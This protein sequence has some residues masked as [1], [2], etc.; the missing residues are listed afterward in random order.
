[1]LSVV[2]GMAGQWPLVVPILL[3]LGL[4]PL[5]L[6]VNNKGH[7]DHANALLLWSIFLL[8]CTLLWLGQGLQSVAVLTF[9]VILLVAGLLTNLR[10]FVALLVAMLLYGT[11]LTL[12]TEVWHLRQNG[13][14]PTPLRY[15]LNYSLVLSAGA[16]AAWIA[17]TDLRNVLEDLQIQIV[18]HRDS[19]QR[20]R[21]LSQHDNLTEL[22][23]RFLGRELVEA[24]I[25][26]AERN[27]TRVALVFVDLDHFKSIDDSLGHIAGDAYLQ[28]VAKRLQASVR[29]AD[30]VARQ[31]GD[32][33]VIGLADV[34]DSTSVA[35][36]AQTVVSCFDAP[37]DL[38]GS[39]VQGSCS[40]GVAMYP[41]DG[42]DYESLLRMSD[43]AMY[44]AKAAG[45]NRYRFFGEVEDIGSHP[46]PAPDRA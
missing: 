15:W 28:Q 39:K 21:F 14:S 43:T 46:P 35:K 42:S 12:F 1:L 22:P 34:S 13:V 31:G 37:F 26:R 40:V 45:R 18:R 38:R 16:Y 8:V 20:Y 5:C 29:R 19:E 7:S 6:W 24:A 44:L 32:E 30:M 41:E 23:N 9:P 33:F 17:V 25:A 11:V 3:C 4:L 10:H 36:V 27:G 2:Y